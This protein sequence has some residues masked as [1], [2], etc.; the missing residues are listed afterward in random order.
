[1]FFQY[2]FQVKVNQTLSIMTDDQPFCLASRCEEL[3]DKVM[4]TQLAE[5]RRHER[6]PVSWSG[7]LITNDVMQDCEVRDFSQGGAMVSSADSIP[8]DR[9]ITLRVPRTG[10]FVGQV[11]WRNDDRMGLSFVN[12]SA[13]PEETGEQGLPDTQLIGLDP[14]AGY[15]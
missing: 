2:L 4:H 15:D 5:R 9:S 3:K 12:V 13:R 1:M 7:T 14:F 10:V 8:M 11:A 6:T